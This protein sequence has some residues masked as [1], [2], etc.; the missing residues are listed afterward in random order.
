MRVEELMEEQQLHRWV[1]H[2]QYQVVRQE[3]FLV[4]LIVERATSFAGHVL[5]RH[6][7]LVAVNC[8]LSGKKRF[9]NKMNLVFSHLHHRQHRHPPAIHGS[10]NTQNPAQIAT[11]QFRKT[12]AVIR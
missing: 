4:L 2:R 5:G 12:M 8:G 10:Q 11:L 7:I 6:M 1:A 9:Q 3:K